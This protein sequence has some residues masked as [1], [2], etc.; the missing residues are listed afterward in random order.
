MIIITGLGRCGTSFFL[1]LFQECGFGVG[2]SLSW[3][4]EV[5]AGME[6]TPAY[7]ISRDMY[8]DFIRNEYC[9]H[10]I[11][12]EKLICGKVD[13]D[14]KVNNDYWEGEISIRDRILRLDKMTPDSREEGVV[15]VIKDPRITWHPDIIENWWN[16]RNGDIRLIILHRKFE[17]IIRSREKYSML[18]HNNNLHFKDPKRW[19]DLRK[20][21]EDFADFITRVI[22]LDIP[23]VLMFYPNFMFH[24]PM[25]IYSKI[26]NN[27][28][29]DM[30][31]K[32]INFAEV[33]HRIID[34]N[35]ISE[36]N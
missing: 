35:K 31:C 27:L 8:D 9:E 26:I 2:K 20:F 13:L 1:K 4:D 15:E 22:K 36:F 3:N 32:G 5:N 29:V 23:Y 6:L 14:K 28:G 21:K 24:N 33:W 10:P 19:E 34:K 18:M 30:N 17:D 25:F 7:A 11:T 12:K 16:V